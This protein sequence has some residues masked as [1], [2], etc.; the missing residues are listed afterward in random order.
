M[1]GAPRSRGA[2]AYNRRAVSHQRA[3]TALLLVLI[4]ACAAAFLRAEQLK[5]RHSAVGHP[6]VGQSFSPGCSDPGCNPQAT[7]EFTLRQPQ[8]LGL[9]IVD[10][11]GDVV[12]QL[13]DRGYGKGPVRESWDGRRDDGSTAADGRY[14][15]RVTL[16]DG[17]RLTI[18][19]PIVLDTKPPGITLGPVRRGKTSVAVPY[20]RSEGNVRAMMIVRKGDRIVLQKRRLVPKVAHLRYSLLKPG[21]Y[22]VE[23]LAVDKAGNRTPDPPSFPVTVP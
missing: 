22:T 16:A 18:P 23:I 4:A 15:L 21:T 20:T 7:L 8:K 3:A 19:D 2:P 10:P 12:R 5:L 13:A 11:Q 9:A 14:K 1:Q 17:R 6:H